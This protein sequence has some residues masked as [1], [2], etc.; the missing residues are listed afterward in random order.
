M[1]T[2]GAVTVARSDWGIYQPILKRIEAHPDLRLHLLVS[3]AHLS[4]EFGLTVN[5]IEQDG[6]TVGER[7]EML[8]SSDSPEG[9]AKSIGLGVIGFA[10]A[11]TRYRPDL[12]L[13]LG[14]RFEMHAAALAALPFGIPVAHIHGGEVTAG[15]IDEALRHSI[16]KLSHLHFVS[17]D[18]YARRVE[19]LGES[20]WR[21]TTA[22]APS[23]DRMASIPAL[24]AAELESRLGVRM[25]PAPLLV[26]FHPPT[27]AFTEVE[28]QTA[29]LLAA[30]AEADMPIVFTQ[31]NADTGGRQIARMIDEF[32]ATHPRASRVDNFGTQAY[33]SMMRLAASMVGNSSSGIIEAV[34]FGLSVVNVGSRQMGRVRAENVVDVGCRRAEILAGIRKALSPEFKSRVLQLSNPYNKGGAS[35]I[36]VERLRS[37]ALDERLTMKQF[38][39]LPQPIGVV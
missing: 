21:I 26:T 9:I 23:L 22:G 3:G 37:V 30:L 6:F 38:H 4:P 10:Q 16:T 32:V 29:E 19:Q 13:V 33:F 11:Y 20:P 5:D 31:P 8:M 12:L 17:T 15:A 27:L 18:E 14:D 7:V 28:Y 25:I 24:S 35:A 34:S 2:I 36:I 1:R 39:D